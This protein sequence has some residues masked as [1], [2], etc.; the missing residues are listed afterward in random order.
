MSRLLLSHESPCELQ[1]KNFGSRMGRDNKNRSVLNCLRI[2]VCPKNPGLPQSI[3]ILF[4]WDWNPQS[5]KF[6]GGV[7]ILRD[8]NIAMKN[9]PG[10]KMYILLKMG[11]FQPAMLVYQRLISP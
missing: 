8:S 6:S 11:I 9:G 2:Q 1:E 5:Y 4:G 7:W 10:L 3:P